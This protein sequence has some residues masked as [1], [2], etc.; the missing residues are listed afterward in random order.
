MREWENGRGQVNASGESSFSGAE[1]LTS[2]LFV[3]GK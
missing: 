2:F 1:G 3:E